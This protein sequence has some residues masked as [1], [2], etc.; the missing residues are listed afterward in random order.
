MIYEYVKQHYGVPAC[1]GRKVIVDGK[2]GVIAKD[3]G[4]HIGVNFDEDK[5]GVISNCHPTWRVEYGG[6]TK[7]RSMTRSQRRYQEFLE[8]GDCYDSFAHFLGVY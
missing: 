3:K 1:T 2:H 5:P 8:V 4:H 7:I 6:M